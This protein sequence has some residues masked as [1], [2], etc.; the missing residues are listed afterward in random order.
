MISNVSNIS[1]GST[2]KASN[3]NNIQYEYAQFRGYAMDKAEECEGVVSGYEDKVEERPPYNFTSTTTMIVP[4]N[5]DRSVETFCKR[6]GIK[7]TK[8]TNEDLM[9]P[10]TIED[11]IQ[12]APRGT[13]IKKV[14]VEKL[15]DLMQGQRTNFD[16]CNNVY[17]RYFNDEITYMM[18]SGDKIP[19]SSLYV[20]PVGDSVENAVGYI[21]NFGAE[22]LN[23]EQISFDL[24]QRTNSPDHCTFFALKEMGLKSIPVYVNADTLAV[25]NA[26]GIFED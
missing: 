5:M 18:K 25:G 17:R 1:F 22:N 26:L 14:N 4:D 2:Y 10:E 21:N 6:N 8:M 24:H 13:Q 15:E 12:A 16:H 20:V 9:N 11:R 23:E 19:A 7:F 3:K